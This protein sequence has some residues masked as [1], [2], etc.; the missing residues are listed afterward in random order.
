[1]ETEETLQVIPVDQMTNLSAMEAQSRAEYDT[2]IATAKRY[3]RD[4]T[5]M[6]NNS[7]AIVTMDKKTAEACRYALPRG[8]K[9]ISGPS[10]HMAR[11][12]AQQ[13]GNLRVTAAVKMTTDK[14]IISEAVAF[15]LETNYAVKVEV[16]RRITKKDGGRFDDDMVMVAGNATNAIALR[17]A[18]LNVIPKSITDSVYNAA[19]EK[20]T[21]DLSDENKLIARRNEIFQKMQDSYKVKEDQILQVLNLKSI[22]QVKAEQ[23]SDLIAIGQ[24]IKDGDTTIE[25][26]FYKATTKDIAPEAKTVADAMDKA[27][28]KGKLAHAS[29]ELFDEKKK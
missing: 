3:P 4:L 21:G 19:L 28:N 17:Q 15:D 13:Y 12:M 23:I 18:I 22:N 6:R 9:T 27:I 2:Q 14:E 11:I 16:H 29:G 10:V 20:I 24:A 8:G 5:R 7:I 1:M 26:V 25:E